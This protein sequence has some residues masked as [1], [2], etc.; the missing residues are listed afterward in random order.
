[1]FFAPTCKI[2]IA[3]DEKTSAGLFTFREFGIYNIATPNSKKQIERIK[4]VTISRS[5]ETVVDNAKVSLSNLH[6][7]HTRNIEN[8]YRRG[9]FVEMSIGADDNNNIEFKGYLTNVK[10]V[11]NNISLLFWDYSYLFS[12]TRVRERTFKE[13]ATAQ[14]VLQY[15]ADEVNRVQKDKI[16]KGRDANGEEINDD[17]VVAIDKTLVS[18]YLPNFLI[19]PTSALNVLYQVQGRLPYPIYFR[20]NIL[21]LWR[22]YRQD[23]ATK[24]QKVLLTINRNVKSFN[25]EYIREKEREFVVECI[26]VRK[27]GQV[28]VGRASTGELDQGELIRWH[29]PMPTKKTNEKGELVDIK[30]KDIENE[31][32]MR[33]KSLLDRFSYDGFEGTITTWITHNLDR[34]QDTTIPTFIDRSHIIELTDRRYE[35]RETD[36]Y[37]TSYTLTLDIMAGTQRVMNVAQPL[38]D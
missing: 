4:N 19:K 26:T 27:N 36:Y 1:M 28:L 35:S 8:K 17:I 16:Q 6:R 23:T 15:L 22:R 9:Q 38:E 11:N 13:D 37:V 18:F 14:D 20:D 2:R 12:I 24:G 31:L 30:A 21:C 29:I 7:T 32:K 5:V 3:N 33:A 10:V 34:I 25:L